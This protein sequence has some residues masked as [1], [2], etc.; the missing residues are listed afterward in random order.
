MNKLV[1]FIVI[2]LGL[3]GC[4]SDVSDYRNSSPKL[5]IK[6][7]FTGKLVGWGTITKYD[8]K[9][10][11]R[12]CVEVIGTWQGNKGELDETFYFLDGEVS[13][14]VWQLNL[15]GNGKYTGKAHD[16]IGTAK[17]QQTGMAFNWQ[18]ELDV[19]I[20]NDMIRFDM[21]D[22]MYKLDDDRVMNKTAMN[23]YGI[24]VADITLFFDKSVEQCSNR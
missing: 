16:V 6:H 22:W 12:F 18:Y 19:A 14:R 7:Y 5:D 23:K 10:T 11:R 21:D 4:S 9:V 24:T 2:I 8:N 1:S 15:D 3:L 17:G 20:D 13:K